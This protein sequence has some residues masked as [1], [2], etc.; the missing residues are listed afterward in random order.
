[1]SNQM[2]QRVSPLSF[3]PHVKMSFVFRTIQSHVAARHINSVRLLFFPRMIWMK[4]AK[5]DWLH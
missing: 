5:I 2:S 1:M 4:D 3:Y